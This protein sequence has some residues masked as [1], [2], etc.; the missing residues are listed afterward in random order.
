MDLRSLLLQK[1]FIVR[2][3]RG[4]LQGFLIRKLKLIFS[5]LIIRIPFLE[6]SQK[7]KFISLDTLKRLDDSD[8]KKFGMANDK[9]DLARKLIR[10]KRINDN[11]MLS[12]LSFLISYDRYKNFTIFDLKDFLKEREPSIEDLKSF[13]NIFVSPFAEYGDFERAEEILLWTR[14]ELDKKM[15]RKIGIYNESSFFTSIGHM[16]LLVNLLKAVDLKIIDKENTD[17]N[18]VITSTPVSNL[19]YSKLLLDKC[20][21][22]GLIINEKPDCTFLDLEPNLELWPTSCTNNYS[23]RAQIEGLVEGCWEIENGKKFM[24]PTKKHLEIASKLFLENYGEIPQ[25]F[26]GMHFR[27]ANDKKTLRNTERSTVIYVIDYLR[28]KGL[29]SILVGTKSSKKF[30]FKESIYNL[31]DS[32]N[33][34]DTTKLNL[35]RYER[36]CIQLFVWSRSRFFVGSLSGG[37]MPPRVFGVPTIYV[38]MHPQTHLRMSTRFDHTIPKR[39]FFMEENRFLSHEELFEEKHIAA[40]SE[41]IEFVKSKG[42]KV[43][44]CDLNKLNQSLSDMITYTNGSIKS[45]EWKLSDQKS[46]INSL[47]KI[48]EKGEFLKFEYGSKTY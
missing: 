13:Q 41:N 3:I 27:V 17:L 21:E 48:L 12:K 9:G 24:L 39:I 11:F 42:Y 22:R 36:E 31:E 32:T 20:Y 46:Y 45:Q 40:Q 47:Q 8:V 25:N 38:D 16:T 34:I 6:Y 33:L 15:N 44:S 28:K 5:N 7:I 37:T 18:F 14:K 4:N 1:I 43:F 19:E 30:H 29:K 35:S 26:V 10:D 2:V 23:L